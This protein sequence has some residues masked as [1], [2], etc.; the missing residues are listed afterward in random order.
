MFD[1]I[2]RF[3]MIFSI[4]IIL[5]RWLTI[6]HRMTV[7]TDV[8]EGLSRK[9]KVPLCNIFRKSTEKCVFDVQLGKNYLKK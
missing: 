4:F 5:F 7:L 1:T 6:V 9:K 8:W 2:R 3:E